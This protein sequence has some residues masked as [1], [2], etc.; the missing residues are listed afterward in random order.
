MFATKEVLIN[1][2]T[3][4]SLKWAMFGI[5]VFAAVGLSLMTSPPPDHDNVSVRFE[6]PPDWKVVGETEAVHDSG[7]RISFQARRDT[8]AKRD[9]EQS[10]IRQPRENMLAVRSVQLTRFSGIR[11]L[12]RERS[13]GY[14]VEEV[15]SAADGQYRIMIRSFRRYDDKAQAA[16]IDAFVEHVFRTAHFYRE[17][18][19]G[20][21]SMQDQ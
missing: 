14:G 18:G 6:L 4:R 8:S 1:S 13:P 5:G 17:G 20:L 11:V 2:S 12:Y 7:L 21:L 10:L 16:V 9:F 15:I 3:S 19:T